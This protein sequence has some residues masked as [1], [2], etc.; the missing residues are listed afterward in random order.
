[1]PFFTPAGERVP[2]EHVGGPGAEGLVERIVRLDESGH[3][4]A[5]WAEAGFRVDVLLFDP[6][7]SRGRMDL[8]AFDPHLPIDERN[9][10]R[11]EVVRRSHA[12]LRPRHTTLAASARRVAAHLADLRRTA[13]RDEAAWLGPRW[14]P[15]IEERGL[16]RI[17][18]RGRCLILDALDTPNPPGAAVG[19]RAVRRGRRRPPPR[20]AGGVRHRTVPRAAH[21]PRAGP[22]PGRADEPHRPAP[23]GPRR[24]VPAAPP[25]P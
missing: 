9:R 6:R 24:A 14:L 5:A 21:S 4:A 15:N 12:W 13:P 18:V 8:A 16:L 7:W 20:R 17:D 23:A 19:Q 2:E 1:M 11:E 3:P 25:W 10:V 22:P